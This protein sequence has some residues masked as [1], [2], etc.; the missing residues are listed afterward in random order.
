VIAASLETSVIPGNELLY[1][2]FN[3]LQAAP[4]SDKDSLMD[5]INLIDAELTT[6]SCKK[7]A[8]GNGFSRVYMPSVAFHAKASTVKP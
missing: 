4:I 2:L 1:R 5:N 7:S 3:G 6:D 8:P